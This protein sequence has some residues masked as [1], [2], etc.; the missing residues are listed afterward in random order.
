MY[1]CALCKGLWE[2]PVPSEV[3]DIILWLAFRN[4]TLRS[5]SSASKEQVSRH[6]TADSS[7]GCQI[8]P[9]AGTRLRASFEGRDKKCLYPIKAIPRAVPFF[10]SAKSFWSHFSIHVEKLSPYPLQRHAPPYLRAALCPI[11]RGSQGSFDLPQCLQSFSLQPCHKA[12]SLGPCDS[13]TNSSCGVLAER[14]CAFC[15][16]SLS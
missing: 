16:T 3:S 15:A 4:I 13:K 8:C 14:G 7:P 1:S 12:F 6:C 10:P 5:E 9:Q 11:S 2:K